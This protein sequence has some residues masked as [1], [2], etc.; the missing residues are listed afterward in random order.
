MAMYRCAVCGSPNV[1]KSESNGGFSYSKAMVGTAVFGSIGA[2]AGINGKKTSAYTCPDCGNTLPQPMDNITKDKIDLVMTNPD[3]LASKIFPD[4]YE[5]YAYLRRE[6][7][8]ANSAAVEKASAFSTDYANPLDISEKDFRHAAKTFCSA[9]DQLQGCWVSLC[10]DSVFAKARARITDMDIVS[11][12]LRCARTI[13]Y[14]IPAYPALVMMNVDYTHSGL[15]RNY[16]CAAAIIHILMENGGKLT[17]EEFYSCV[18]CNSIYQQAFRVLMGSDYQNALTYRQ[19]VI[20][21]RSVSTFTEKEKMLVWFY[22]LKKPYFTVNMCLKNPPS[23]QSLGHERSMNSIL[24]FP[25]KLINFS[26]YIP[27]ST[28]AEEQFAKDMPE[29]A[30][31]ISTA[32]QEIK[33]YESSIRKLSNPTPTQAEITAQRSIDQFR[34]DNAEIDMQIAKLRKKI[35]GKKK[36]AAEIQSLETKTKDNLQQ[37][38]ECNNHIAEVRQQHATEIKEKRSLIEE[39]LVNAR[40]SLDEL[41]EQKSSYIKQFPQWICIV[42]VDSEI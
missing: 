32:Q 30:Q 38:A 33:Q 36:A 12:G 2:V 22:A 35:F 15:G 29:T 42:G 1:T 20:A 23:A 16:L 13:I 31:N 6:K 8:A 39:Q 17:L 4:M 5:R 7:E 34:R 11:E 37:I 10:V 28:S 14:G 41:L 3:L 27:N 24:E 18:M 40:R 9:F 26:L 21:H 19:D 25:F